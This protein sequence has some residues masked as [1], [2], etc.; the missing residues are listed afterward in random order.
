MN[1]ALAIIAL[2]I[3]SPTF[4]VLP[5]SIGV[6]SALPLRLVV[7]L[8]D[9][10]ELLHQYHGGVS[11]LTAWYYELLGAFWLW[12][13]FLLIVAYLTQVA[14]SVRRWALGVW[15]ASIAYFG[16][17]L[18]TQP[19]QRRVWGVTFYTGPQRIAL[20]VSTLMLVVSI[21]GFLAALLHRSSPR[22]TSP[23]PPPLPHP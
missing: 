3:L 11:L 17:I 7:I 12:G 1:R 14:T 16:I 21:L 5:Y 22:V 18:I 13:Y 2:L 6:A 10:T 20:T 15:T 19:W 8:V 4:V 23:I 9:P